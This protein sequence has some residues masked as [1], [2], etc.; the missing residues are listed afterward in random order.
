MSLPKGIFIKKTNIVLTIS[1]G[2]P[3]INERFPRAD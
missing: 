1:I 2:R 3:M